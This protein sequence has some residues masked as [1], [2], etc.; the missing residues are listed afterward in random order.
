MPLTLYS[1]RFSTNA[2]KVRFLLAEL[3]LEHELVEVGRGPLRPAD[4]AALHP[5]ARVPSHLGGDDGSHADEAALA[6]AM[7]AL[8][9]A[10]DGFER[11]LA[12]LDGFTIADCAIAGRLSTVP[13]LPVDL[14]PWP[15]LAGRLTAAFARPAFS[16]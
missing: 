10:L 4:Y 14:E 11:F 16:A 15:I 7:P 3:G 13:K 1:S 2:K 9:D 12:P 6:A 8:A 5:Y